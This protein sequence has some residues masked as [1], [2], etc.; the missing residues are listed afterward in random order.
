MLTAI[1]QIVETGMCDS[2]Y[3]TGPFR[4]KSL[5]NGVMIWLGRYPAIIFVFGNSLRIHFD[6][7]Q[8]H[9]P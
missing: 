8:M 9:A 4:A 7:S 5:K 1:S 3:I 6:E 2:Y